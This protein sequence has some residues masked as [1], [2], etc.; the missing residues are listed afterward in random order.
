L[1][2]RYAQLCFGTIVTRRTRTV[3]VSLPSSLSLVISTGSL[4]QSFDP[5]GCDDGFRQKVVAGC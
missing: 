1:K 2:T 5:R 3:L 4:C